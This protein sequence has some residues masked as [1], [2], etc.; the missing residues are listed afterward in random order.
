MVGAFLDE[1]EHVFRSDEAGRHGGAG[2][3]EHQV[4]REGRYLLFG[5][6]HKSAGG[7]SNNGERFEPDG[8]RQGVDH[9]AG[10]IR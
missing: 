2:A 6:R 1:V 3:G 7:E 8:Q 9:A 10:E 5:E 4:S